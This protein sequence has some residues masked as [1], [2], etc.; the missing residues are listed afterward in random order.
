MRGRDGGG[1]FTPHV[2][3]GPQGLGDQTRTVLPRYRLT[4]PPSPAHSHPSR[5]SLSAKSIPGDPTVSQK[6]EKILEPYNERMVFL[7]SFL[8]LGCRGVYWGLLLK[9]K[10]RKIL[11]FAPL[12]QQRRR[13]GCGGGQTRNSRE[14]RRL[15]RRSTRRMTRSPQY[16]TVL[17]TLPRPHPTSRKSS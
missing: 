10:A 6:E 12:E 11:G 15:F 13:N 1:G 8:F 7:S 16:R 4:L 9:L 3:R 5:D 14:T 2:P 17:P